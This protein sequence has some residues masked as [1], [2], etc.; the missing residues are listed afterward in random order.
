MKKTLRIV[1]GR[2][3]WTDRDGNPC[4]PA[5][6]SAVVTQSGHVV[7]GGSGWPLHSDSAGVHPCQRQAAYDDSVKNG[8]P[9]VFD[10][11]GCA[12]FTSRN[13]RRRYLKKYKIVD[14]DGC[15]GD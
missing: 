14:K 11:N 1:D 9:T 12:V 13:H 5:G 8:V 2:E 6:V 15:Y 4:E 7:H 3:V 10:E